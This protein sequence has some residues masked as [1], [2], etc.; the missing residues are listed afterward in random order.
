MI[1]QL[2]WAL[3]IYWSR[4]DSSRW[5]IG[6]SGWQWQ[7]FG[8]PPITM[9]ILGAILLL[10]WLAVTVSI[11]LNPPATPAAFWGGR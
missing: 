7:H 2:I 4:W 9:Q 8:G 3:S 5:C 6:S 11:M 10:I 1:L